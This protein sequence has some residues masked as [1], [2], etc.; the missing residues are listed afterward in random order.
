MYTAVHVLY[1]FFTAAPGIPQF[2][3]YM[4]NFSFPGF[5]AVQRTI[6]VRTCYGTDSSIIAS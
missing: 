2:Q 3:I 4:C 1:Y 6:P 5:A